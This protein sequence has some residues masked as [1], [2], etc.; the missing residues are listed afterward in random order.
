MDKLIEES[1]LDQDRYD[2]INFLL[3]WRLERTD[4]RTAIQWGQPLVIVPTW[5]KNRTKNTKD[6]KIETRTSKR[7]YFPTQRIFKDIEV[8]E[9]VHTGMDN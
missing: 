5:T 7:Q 9:K 6:E 8:F 1:K 2:Q 4:L 3:F